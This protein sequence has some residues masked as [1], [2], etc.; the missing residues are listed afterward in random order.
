MK[1][2]KQIQERH[3]KERDRTERLNWCE[4]RKRKGERKE[5]IEQNGEKARE[6]GRDD[7]NWESMK[8]ERAWKS[9]FP[10]KSR[11]A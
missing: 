1:T 4:R 2:K 5:W 9:V 6:V 8:N 11:M 7:K 10:K 3:F